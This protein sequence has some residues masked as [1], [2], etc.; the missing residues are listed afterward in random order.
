MS[1]CSFTSSAAREEAAVNSAAAWERVTVPVDLL[2]PFC[3][4]LELDGYYA[5]VSQTCP[6]FLLMVPLPHP[7]ARFSIL[8]MTDATSSCRHDVRRNGVLIRLAQL[9]I[10]S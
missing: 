2:N 3:L 6:R 8:P 1:H 10:S 4:E 5:E 9:S 7:V